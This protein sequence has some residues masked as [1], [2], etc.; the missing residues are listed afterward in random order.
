MVKKIFFLA[1]LLTG[2]TAIGFREGES[3]SRPN[4]MIQFKTSAT[5]QNGVVYLRDIATVK[6]FPRSWVDRINQARIGDAPEVGEVLI[7]SRE[8]IIAQVERANLLSYIASKGIPDQ[9]EVF[10]EGQVVEAEDIAQILEDHLRT[11]VLDPRKSLAVRDLQGYEPITLPPGPYTCELT[12]PDSV[13]RGG[14]FAATL[15]FFQEG[16]LSGK[17]RVRAR[18]EIHGFVVA[19]RNGLRRHQE[20]GEKDVL[21]VKKDI[22]LIPPDAITE[23]KEA[24]GKRMTLS[25]NGQEILRQ[26]MVEAIP[27]VKK[28]DRV[29]III[30][31]ERFKITTLG[32]VKEEGRR[33]EWVKLMNISSKKEVSGRVID[34]HTVLVE[35]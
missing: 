26:S 19:V 11:K 12:V 30:D 9:I 32:E 5:V 8:E 14:A 18:A 24:L 27:L 10:R 33:G 16:R 34:A 29:L 23:V 2:V 28:G 31:N 1:L 7:L 20:L 6:G 35:F 22:N 3:A 4:L 13:S 17:T 21:L 25:L 15:S